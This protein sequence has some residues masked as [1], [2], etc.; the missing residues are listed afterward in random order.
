MYMYSHMIGY[1]NINLVNM[2]GFYF[3]L[4][5]RDIIFHVKIFMKNAL[6]T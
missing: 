5:I 1:N 2:V 4:D 6:W 3:L